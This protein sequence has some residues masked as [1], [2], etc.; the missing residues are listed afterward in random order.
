MGS[1][2]AHTL[3]LYLGSLALETQLPLVYAVRFSL[4]GGFGPLCGCLW[5][6]SLPELQSICLDS[7]N[8]KC[9]Q[10]SR[11]LPQDLYKS[12]HLEGA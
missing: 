7:L 12:L 6:L 11:A 9:G 2:V 3:T 4:Q 10:S 1:L 8:L 5:K